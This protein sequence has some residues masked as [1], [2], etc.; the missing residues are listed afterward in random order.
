[1]LSEF[2]LDFLDGEEECEHTLTAAKEPYRP[3]GSQE[4]KHRFVFD[5]RLSLFFCR[6]KLL[7][8]NFV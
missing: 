8:M 4:T 6:A 2:L 7:M 5:N 3:T 1:M